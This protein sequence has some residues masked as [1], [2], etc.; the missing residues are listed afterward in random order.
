MNPYSTMLYL[1][2]RAAGWKVLETS[3][4]NRLLR[5]LERTDPGDVLH[6]QWSWPLFRSDATYA[7]AQK[8]VETFF[9]ALDAALSRGIRL[10]WTVHNLASHDAEFFELEAQF[11]NFMARRAEIVIQLNDYTETICREMYTIGSAVFVTI[12]HSSYQGIYADAVTVEEARRAFGIPESDSVIGFVGQVRP[13]KGIERLI[14]T[15]AQIQRSG[16]KITVL[17]AGRPREGVDEELLRLV[18]RHGVHCVH[19]FTFVD[20]EDLQL[21]FKATDVM[22]FPYRKVLNSGSAYL[23]SSFGT[24]CVLPREAQFEEL[25]G[26]EEWVGLFSPEDGQDLRRVVEDML[27]ASAQRKMAATAFSRRH[28]PWF[29]SARFLDVL[30]ELPVKGHAA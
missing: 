15:A 1:H 22:V 9:A 19:H 5:H 16:R 13:Y 18:E 24:P 27:D 2:P 10:V 21:W 3:Q 25:F 20:D 6:I 26:D 30:R 11:N 28:L 12:P 7:E 29:M 17:I 8:T 4:V 14:E 23:S